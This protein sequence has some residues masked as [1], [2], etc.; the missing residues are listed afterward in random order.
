MNDAGYTLVEMLVA[1]ALVGLVMTGAAVGARVVAQTETRINT[2]RAVLAGLRGF[3]R[4]ASAGLAGADLADPELGPVSGDGGRFAFPCGVREQCV[5]TIAPGEARL[6]KGGA[7][8]VI[9]LRGLAA[10]GLR[11]F[12]GAGASHAAWPAGDGPL[13]AVALVDGERPAAIVR[14]HS[15][16]PAVCNFD[17]ATGGCDGTGRP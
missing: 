17:V 3:E 2:G 15:D 13:A 4:E 8:R 11:Y 7:E 6:R 16:Q 5:W 14:V 10:P 9:A 12:D 1:L